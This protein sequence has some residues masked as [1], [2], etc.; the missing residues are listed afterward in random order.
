MTILRILVFSSSIIAAT[1]PMYLPSRSGFWLNNGPTINVGLTTAANLS[2]KNGQT[3]DTSFEDVVI[4]KIGSTTEIAKRFVVTK[5]SDM[6][7]VWKH[8]NGMMWKSLP[9]YG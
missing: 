8:I 1:E 6:E 7:K 3:E 5:N 2:M 4:V 9:M